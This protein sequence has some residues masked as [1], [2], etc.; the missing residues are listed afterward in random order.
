LANAGIAW[1][2]EDRDGRVVGALLNIPT[3][4]HFRGRELINATGRAW[5]VDAAFRGYAL[6]LLDE[7]YNQADADLFVNNTINRLAEAPH[8]DYASRIP[9]GQWNT[10]SSWITGYRGF[11]K[12]A[13][14]RLGVLLPGLFGP[15]ASAS[16]WL[17]DKLSAKRL[18]AA[19]RDIAYETAPNFDARFDEFWQEQLEQSP[20]KLLAARDLKTL[21]WHSSNEV[22]APGVVANLSPDRNRL[23]IGECDDRASAR[24]KQLRTAL[25]DASIESPP[26]DE[27]RETIWS[28]LLTNMSMSVLCL[29]SGQTARALRDDPSLRDVIPRVLDEANAIAQNFIPGVQRV[30]RTGPAPQHK[31]SILQDYERGRAME[32][33][34]LVRAPAAF[35]RKAGL[36]TPMLDLIAALA[37]QKARDKGLYQAQYSAGG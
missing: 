26:L 7:Y 22:I 9:L 11:A 34:A 31:P 30:T 12:K 21:T 29:L 33:D 13:L 2:L 3:L 25:T 18:P 10:V 4:Y 5:A 32:I 19:Q 16:L 1:V 27:I 14:Q 37:I 8:Q 20:D 15:P 35:A 6:W 24:I 36:S 23:L 28:K 17:R